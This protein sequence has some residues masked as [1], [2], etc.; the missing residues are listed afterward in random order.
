MKALVVLLLVPAL[1]VAEPCKRRHGLRSGAT[2][3]CSGILT[4]KAKAIEGARC[5]RVHLPKEKAEHAYTR[6]TMAADLALEASRTS[7]CRDELKRVR[8]QP[9]RSRGVPEW[10]AGAAVVVGVV[11]G[12][13]LRGAAN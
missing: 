8:S 4:P 2:A 10:L 1:A 12:W 5:V 13:L 6:A 7:I 11:A 3:P 9:A